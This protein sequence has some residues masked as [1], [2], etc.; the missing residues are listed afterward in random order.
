MPVDP[1]ARFRRLYSQAERARIH[2]P[3]AM[4]LATAGAGRPSARFVL[5]KGVADDGFVFF[6]DARSRKGRDL[7]K[8]P[9]AALTFYWDKIGRQVRIEGRVREVSKAEAD[10]YWESRPRESRL[11]ARASRQD[12]E[13]SSR[14]ALLA[15]WRRLARE[16]RGR[17]IPRPRTWTGFRVVPDTIEF[18][19]RRAHRLHEREE[20]VRTR[21]GW[22]RRLLQP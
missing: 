6:T 18:W 11:A 8:N 1:I 19:T 2:L 17:P 3:H 7:R 5:L 9:R 15:R 22:R 21:R 16:F 13:L 14:A 4:A 10:A 20:F 12:D